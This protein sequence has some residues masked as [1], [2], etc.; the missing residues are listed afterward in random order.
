MRN[1]QNSTL[2]FSGG[3]LLTICLTLL[4]FGGTVRSAEPQINNTAPPELVLQT[5]HASRINSSVFAPGNQ[6]LA[7]AGADQVIK[8]WDLPT[9]REMRTLTGHTGWIKSLSTNNKG[10]LLASGS[11]DR[12]VKIWEVESGRVVH[13]LKGHTK[14]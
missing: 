4:Q 14:P 9:G 7:S 1:W 13:T 5:G 11:V 2:T 8:I 3:L 10:D 12:S 6:W